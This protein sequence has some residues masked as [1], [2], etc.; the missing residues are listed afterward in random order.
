LADLEILFLGTGSAVPTEER[1]LSCV[2]IYFENEL[3]FF[4]A[5]EGAQR[6]AIVAGV[7]LNKDCSIFIT[8]M[9]GDH[10]VGLLGLIQTMALNRRQK[11]LR[12]FGP[13][14]ISDFVIS[15]QRILGFGLTFD[16]HLKTTRQ[17][18][19]YDSI[20]PGFRVLASRSKHSRISYAYVFE[21][22]PRPGRFDVKKAIS[23]GIPEGPLW[24][25]LQRG[26]SVRS[27]KNRMVRPS[28]VLGKP[29]PGK[30]IGI[31]GDTRPSDSLAKFFKGCDVVIFDSTY[32]DEHSSLAK[33]NMHSTSREAAWV[34][35]RAGAKALFL[36]HFSA[37]YRSVS[38][39]VR[40]ARE[41]FPN[42]FAASD[43][44]L[45]KVK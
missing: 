4:D 12:I 20:K 29:R 22:K 18:V 33:E 45:Y 27:E 3:L 36:T 21:E 31:S 26:E 37:R 34:A 38:Q 43:Q 9:H 14:G 6:A 40:Q 11:P 17:G 2:V 8:H 25:K 30:K 28:Q 35:K 19:V 44:M 5:G 10:S 41:V 13:K 39:L 42:T 24:G 32:S 7:G 16:V 23:L 1:G 15:N